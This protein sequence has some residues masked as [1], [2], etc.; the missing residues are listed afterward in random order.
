M[1][2]PIEY[3]INELAKPSVGE[4]LRA[5]TALAAMGSAASS[6][7]PALQRQANRFNPLLRAR[8]LEAIARI[9]DSHDPT[10]KQHH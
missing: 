10:L 5:I 3:W 9:T 7:L 1:D 4:R 2:Q 8:A 6:A